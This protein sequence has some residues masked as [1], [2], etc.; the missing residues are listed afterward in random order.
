MIPVAGQII[1]NS[2]GLSRSIFGIPIAK[3]GVAD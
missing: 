2:L 1:G 3:Q